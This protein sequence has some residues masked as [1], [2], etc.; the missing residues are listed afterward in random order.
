MGGPETR[1]GWSHSFQRWMQMFHALARTERQLREIFRAA[2]LFR[3][4]WN[5]PMPGVA[6]TVTRRHRQ[7]IGGRVKNPWR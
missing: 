6:A 1:R 7:D 3:K 2:R 4:A 5:L